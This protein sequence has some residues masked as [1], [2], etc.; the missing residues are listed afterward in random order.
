MSS[1]LQTSIMSYWSTNADS[2]EQPV[3]WDAF[4]AVVRGE[5]ISAIKTAR[6]DHNSEIV[7]LQKRD[8][9]CA[10]EHTYTPSDDKYTSLLEV[11]R[12]L[13]L[14]FME[15]A[16]TEAGRRAESLFSQGDKSDKLLAMLVAEQKSL[17]SIPVLSR[18]DLVTDPSS[19][20]TEF[21]NYCSSFYA[22]I[23][24]NEPF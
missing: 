18:G 8:C 21:V 11:R 13:S 1:Q 14:H 20:L 7:V 17:V 10:R 19:I 6:K 16:H 3:V 9:E 2:A 5:S 12:L 22:P 15:L 24:P 23:P 4:K